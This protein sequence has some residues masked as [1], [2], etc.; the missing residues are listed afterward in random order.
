MLGQ[1]TTLIVVY[2]G[3]GLTFNLPISLLLVTTLAIV[4]LVY[5]IR[6]PQALQLGEKE[7]KGHLTFDLVQLSALLYFT[8]GL[9]NPF[10]LL[11][12]VPVTVSATILSRRATRHLLIFALI[13]CMALVFF[14]EPLP[15]K[16]ETIEPA[17]IYVWGLWI[18]L[19]ISMMFLTNYVGQVASD[20]RIRL[21]ALLATEDALSQEEQKS[22]M[23][24]LA[25]SAAHELG[26]PLGTI[27]LTTKELLSIIPETDDLFEDVKIIDTEVSR[28]REILTNLSKNS[29]KVE[30][31]YFAIQSL[32][33]VLQQII[34]PFNGGIIKINI[35]ENENNI[36]PLPKIRRL[37]EILH[38][39]TS[40]LENAVRFAQSEVD[41]KIGWTEKGLILKI[42]DDGPGFDDRIILDLGEPYI[43]SKFAGSGK[44]RKAVTSVG[45]GLGI[46]MGKSL[47]ERTGGKIT[48][49]NSYVG[50]AEVSLMWSKQTIE[51]MIN[52]SKIDER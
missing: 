41:I 22:A 33:I 19:G 50:G 10:A 35:I 24:A 38:G 37:P 4:N 18:G 39:I 9:I 40:F 44:N 15:W 49:K 5:G 46:F 20:A 13:L 16:G 23:G 27:A 2:Y 42:I 7:V 25:T 51:T 28:C 21:D 8:G 6:Y 11:L 31:D 3:L 52:I 26:T 29:H 43:K 47:I 1:V 36:T 48:F 30:E 34:S 17:P 12:L 45:Q 32:D 14:H